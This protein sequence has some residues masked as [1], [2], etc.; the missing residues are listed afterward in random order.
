[1]RELVPLFPGARYFNPEQ[2][3]DTTEQPP[4]EVARSIANRLG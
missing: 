1:M 3:V 2:V 4:A